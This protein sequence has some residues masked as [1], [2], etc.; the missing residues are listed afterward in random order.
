[1]AIYEM[2][3]D[4][5]RRET[6]FSY[7]Y[8]QMW[9]E[10]RG[11]TEVANLLPLTRVTESHLQGA[12][13]YSCSRFRTL[14]KFQ[15]KKFQISVCSVIVWRWNQGCS[16]RD[17]LGKVKV[18]RYDIIPGVYVFKSLHKFRLALW[19][20]SVMQKGRMQN[21]RIEGPGTKQFLKLLLVLEILAKRHNLFDL[22]FSV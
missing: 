8:S 12:L 4:L 22:Q 2:K 20:L 14:G 1:M 18:N 3:N 10:I 6:P 9:Q 11:P 19:Y 15:A 16:N 13:M 21:H 17:R 5:H 7:R